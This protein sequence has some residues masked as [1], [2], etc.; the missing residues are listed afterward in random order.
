MKLKKRE[1][2]ALY[3]LAFAGV[4]IALGHI[5]TLELYT[6]PEEVLLIPLILLIV[7]AS[8]I[9]AISIF[10]PNVDRPELFDFTGLALGLVGPY[11]MEPPA[12]IGGKL[13]ML[14]I[15]LAIGFSIVNWINKEDGE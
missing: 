6:V 9:A 14:I 12:S 8:L 11:M 2:K 10:I 7:S 5:S 13:L 1:I 15:T 3:H 4:G